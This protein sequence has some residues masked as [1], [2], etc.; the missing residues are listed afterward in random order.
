MIKKWFCHIKKN[1]GGVEQA[2]VF[3]VDSD[4]FLFSIQ[5]FRYFQVCAHVTL[6]SKE[7]AMKIHKSIQLMSDELSLDSSERFKLPKTI[8]QRLQASE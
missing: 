2:K 7:F 6:K 8:I 3:M 5:I 1:H 4:S